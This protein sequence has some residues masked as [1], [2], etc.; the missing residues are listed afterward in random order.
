MHTEISISP[1]PGLFEETYFG[2]ACNI[3]SASIWGSILLIA[4]VCTGLANKM[5][6][7]VIIPVSL[8]IAL[9]TA[10]T[11]SMNAQKKFC[12]A[13]LSQFAEYIKKTNNFYN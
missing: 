10:C 4:L 12:Q 13:L 5:I 6:I 11:I 2:Y 3:V 1:A 9:W 8:L 7:P